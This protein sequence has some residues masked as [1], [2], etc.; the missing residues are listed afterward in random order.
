[1]ESKYFFPKLIILATGMNS[2]FFVQ[3]VTALQSCVSAELFSANLCLHQDFTLKLSFLAVI[4]AVSKPTL[5]L[6]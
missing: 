3:H 5:P 4:N 2:S 6:H 1:M